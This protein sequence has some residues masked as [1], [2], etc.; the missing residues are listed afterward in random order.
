MV[1]RREYLL[2]LLLVSSFIGY[3][4]APSAEEIDTTASVTFLPNPSVP[5]YPDEKD[6]QQR[7]G[8]TQPFKKQPTLTKPTVT[9]G[10]LGRLPQTG[11]KKLPLILGGIVVISSLF[12]WYLRS[13][14]LKNKAVK[15]R[16]EELKYEKNN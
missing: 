5:L 16:M 13:Y 8:A 2:I 11:E 14:I 6:Q 3:P 7:D 1:S 10:I 12:L 15:S 9:T 4:L